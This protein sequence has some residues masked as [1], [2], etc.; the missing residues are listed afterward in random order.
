[1]S[2]KKRVAASGGSAAVLE[3]L[4]ESTNQEVTEAT[5]D[6]ANQETVEEFSREAEPGEE[7][8]REQALAR[9]AVLDPGID[10]SELSNDELRQELASAEAPPYDPC[11]EESAEATELASASEA[12]TVVEPPSQSRDELKAKLADLEV[13]LEAAKAAKQ[14]KRVASGSKPRPN[15]KYTLLNRAPGWTQTPQVIQI[16]Q[17]LFD[18]AVQER[19]K[20][21]DGSVVIPEP[22]LF[23]LI[24]AGVKTGVLRTRQPPV[25]I[26]QYYKSQLV[27]H[28][29]LRWQ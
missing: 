6:R 21:E 16:Q 24:E 18:P 13:A 17:I 19:F 12:A 23:A 29:V 14:G 7:A 28:D 11:A 25:R 1:M 22:E 9:L 5:H 4:P 8:A 2:N 27:G 20:Q 10:Y 15:V 3:A 26:F